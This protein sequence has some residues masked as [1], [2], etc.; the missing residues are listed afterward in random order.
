[1]NRYLGFLCVAMYVEQDVGII[2]ML[3]NIY[4]TRNNACEKIT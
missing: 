4:M 1:M 2:D 3:L